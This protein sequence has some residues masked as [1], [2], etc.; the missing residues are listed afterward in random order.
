MTT[1]HRASIAFTFLA[2]AAFFCA[3]ALA[4]PQEPP[5]APRAPGPPPTHLFSVVMVQ[6]ESEGASSFTGLPEAARKAIED[7]KDFLP[8]KAYKLTD[9]ALMR[10]ARDAS[11][12]LK[13]LD[14]GDYEVRMH[15]SRA[16]ETGDQEIF[17]NM[18]QVRRLNPMPEPSGGI[19]GG[20]ASEEA[21]ERASALA[22][23]RPLIET[24]FGMHVGETVVVGSSRL[25]G[26]RT[27][28]VVLLTAV[29]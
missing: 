23:D 21:Y 24:A 2:I 4:A 9:A 28:L 3:P 20:K 27:A 16:E 26:G 5:R 7:L 6:A 18:F 10:T 19:K 15:Y 22:A 12:R 8:Y 11:T 14:G 17:V 1:T 29:N 13:G 25:D